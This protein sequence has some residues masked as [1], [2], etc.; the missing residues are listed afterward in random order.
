MLL[1]KRVQG[2]RFV[3]LLPDGRECWVSVEEF[4]GREVTLGIVGPSDI[5]FLR[6]EILPRGRNGHVRRAAVQ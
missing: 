3:V 6:E 2:E 4:R 5:R 1:I